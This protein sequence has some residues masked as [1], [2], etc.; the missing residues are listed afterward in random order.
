MITDEMTTKSKFDSSTT[1]SICEEGFGVTKEKSI[2][3]KT[4]TFRVWHILL[5]LT[6]ILTIIAV[7]AGVSAKYAPVS[8]TAL[9]FVIKLPLKCSFIYFFFRKQLP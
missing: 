4:C 2:L 3:Q 8:G 1:L 9:I 7:V 5:L 6:M